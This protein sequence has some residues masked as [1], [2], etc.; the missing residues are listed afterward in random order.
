MALIEGPGGTTIRHAHRT[1]LVAL[2]L[3]AAGALAACSSTKV[4]HEHDASAPFSDYET[5]SIV[6]SK[7]IED[8]TIR[9]VVERL[10]A[11][12]LERK[13]LTEVDDGSD[14]LVTYDGRADSK[15]QIATGLGYAVETIDGETTVYTVGRGVPVGILVIHL[16]DSS[17]A[18]MV[19]RATAQKAIKA[20][21]DPDTRLKRL[22][23]A[24]ATM[25]ASYPPKG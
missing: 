8:T 3:A 18:Q 17:N 13:G 4:A 12:E 7:S 2:A 19:W 20:G 25:F 5:F 11:K 9:A 15:E 10:I 16:V 1:A 22:E 24:L 21:A 23:E 6:P 14:L